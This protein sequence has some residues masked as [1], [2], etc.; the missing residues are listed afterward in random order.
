MKNLLFFLILSG[1]NSFAIAEWIE[2]DTNK[3]IGLTVYANPATI[4]RSGDK[5]EM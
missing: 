3:G 2:V 1:T 4:V 5:V